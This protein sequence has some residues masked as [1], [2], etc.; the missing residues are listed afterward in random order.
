[1]MVHSTLQWLIKHVRLCETSAYIYYHSA[2]I[3][4]VMFNQPPTSRRFLIPDSGD[5]VDITDVVSGSANS[6]CYCFCYSLHS[7]LEL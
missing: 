4:V 7:F 6:C 3:K 1:M 2:D 5:F